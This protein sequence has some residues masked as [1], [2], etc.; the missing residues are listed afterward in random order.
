MARDPRSWGTTGRRGRGGA[1]W[2]L[3]ELVRGAA[4]QC[5]AHRTFLTIRLGNLEKPLFT[6]PTDV[7]SSRAAI[8]VATLAALAVA[9]LAVLP[10]VMANASPASVAD[11][12]Q[13]TLTQQASYGFWSD[14][15]VPSVKSDDETTAVTVGTVFSSSTPGQVY[16]VQYYAAG[17]NRVATTGSLWNE[18]GKRVAAVRFPQTSS[19]GWKT[20]WLR[21]PVKIQPDEKY[22]VSYR[23]PNGRYATEEHVFDSGDSLSVKGLTAHR[24]TYSYEGGR[25]TNTWHGSHYF[26]DVA[27]APSDSDDE[28]PTGEPTPTQEPTPTA[29]PTATP[30]T[31]VPTKPAP[32][33]PVP[34][35]PAPTTP[36]PTT[37]APTTPAPTTPAPTTPAPTTPPSGGFPDASNTGPTGTLDSTSG[38]ITITQAGTIIENRK[39]SGVIQ[40]NAA[41]V[42]IRNTHVVGNIAIGSGGSVTITDSFVDNG[43]SFNVGAVAGNNVTIRRTEVIGGGHS[44]SCTSGCTIEDNW[45]HGQADPTSGDV[46]GDGILFNQASNMVVRHNTLACDMPANGN[47]A[48][49]AGL[50]MYGDWGPVQNVLVENNL[51]K[52]SPAGYCMY[53]G[54]VDGKPYGASNVDVINNV[55]EKGGSSKC[56][57]YGPYSARATDGASSWSGNK[58]SDGT[59]VN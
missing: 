36:V 2:A 24:G 22:T 27:F 9:L 12:S 30:T 1:I 3:P 25:P 16:G 50:A 54:N 14:S 29:E 56:A 18:A 34:T 7:R 28:T 35:K 10:N 53:G 45:F 15:T 58:Y 51:F 48:C 20:V 39:H 55:F 17:A 43:R 42:V 40:V 32:T 11:V 5:C 6:T 21:S 38:N 47:G 44:L 33:T 31:P 23:A 13:R 4:A 52:A 8:A 59:A 57:V 46:H 49:S 26:V 19:D 37:P 41:N